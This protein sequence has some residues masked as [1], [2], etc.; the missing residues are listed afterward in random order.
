MTK[1]LYISY[2]GMT[3]PLGQAQV[4]PY[5]LGLSKKGFKFHILS[6]EKERNYSEFKKS[7][8]DLLTSHNITW[9]RV[10]YTK[11]PPILSTI[12]DIW[13]MRRQAVKLHKKENFEI[14]HCRSYI[15]ALIGLWMKK[16]FGIKLIFDM[17]G[18]WADERV[19][20]GLWNMKNP[21]Y[22][23]IYHYFKK[24]EKQFLSNADYI[25]SLT[26]KAKDE[27]E[28][29][30]LSKRPEHI[31]IIPCCADL[32]HFSDENIDKEFREE[33]KK[34]HGITDGDFI[35]SYL[36][37]LGTWYLLKEMMLFFKCLLEVKP[38]A[39]F[40]FITTEQPDDI[41]ATA[42]KLGINKD[43]L[44]ITKAARAQVPSLLSLSKVSIFFIKPGF[45]KKAT[46]PTKAGEMMAMGIPLICNDKIG[47]MEKIIKETRA[48]TLV[49]KFTEEEFHEII[50]NLDVK[51]DA[52]VRV[53]A[54]KFFSLDSG[55][56][57][58]YDV[59]KK[60][61]SR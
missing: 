55:V 19:E 43:L 35:I 27:I 41:Y 23:I 26:Y 33:F 21:I 16:R 54:Q 7:I 45:S 61:L 50:K 60:L 30:K 17:R 25:I 8:G 9:H 36:G 53:S 38:N 47:D 3:D 5:L 57:K 2:D 58:Y 59:Y 46:S 34:S 10:W 29:F 52:S 39:K 15:T 42:N 49:T 40:L 32:Q 13:K 12:W 51:P 14:V 31:E 6:A 20:G 22:F 37:A 44:I 4:V 11:N 24:K 48:G 56:E 28:G 18:F 1:I